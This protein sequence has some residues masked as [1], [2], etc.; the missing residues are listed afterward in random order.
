MCF[1]L[2]SFYGFTL[3]TLLLKELK[4]PVNRNWSSVQLLSLLP[5]EILRIKFWAISFRRLRFTAIYIASNPVN[6]VFLADTPLGQNRPE[7]RWNLWSFFTVLQLWMEIQSLLRPVNS[8]RSCRSNA[9]PVLRG[10][11]SFGWYGTKF[12]AFGF[13]DV[14]GFIFTYNLN[15]AIK[16]IRI[17]LFLLL[18]VFTLLVVL[19]KNKIRS[20][21]NSFIY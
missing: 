17:Q 1:N 7:N 9:H 15:T 18:T 5:M 12:S 4:S 16:L 20:I 14:A 6:D 19:P 11:L 10:F 13:A 3:K 8:S 2:S 21:I